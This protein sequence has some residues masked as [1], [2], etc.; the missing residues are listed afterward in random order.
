[1]KTASII[2]IK[3]GCWISIGCFVLACV[4][5]HQIFE[6]LAR[7]GSGLWCGNGVA[8]PL[9]LMLNVGVPLATVAVVGL[10]ALWRNGRAA[11]WSVLPTALIVLI[12]SMM[13]LNAGI[14]FFREALPGFHLSDT[15]WWMKTAGM[16]IEV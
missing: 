3:I 2:P 4:R 6:E 5:M 12:C 7:P 16:V 8:A 10:F 13:V 9:G 11:I 15:V 14:R 1:M